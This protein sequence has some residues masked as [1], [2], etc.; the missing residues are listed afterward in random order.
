MNDLAVAVRRQFVVPAPTNRTVGERGFFLVD[1]APFG[2]VRVTVEFVGYSFDWATG[3]PVA[4]RWRILSGSTILD[5][6]GDTFSVALDN[7]EAAAIHP[8]DE[9]HP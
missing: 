1:R 2:Q 5:G 9:A 4:E 7:Y 6:Q 8:L 3:E